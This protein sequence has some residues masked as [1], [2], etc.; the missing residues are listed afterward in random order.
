M[1]R[2][3]AVLLLAGCCPALLCAACTI[4]RSVGAGVDAGDPLAG[5]FEVRLDGPACL[6]Q[7]VRSPTDSGCRVEDVVPNGDGVTFTVRPVPAC[8]TTA[9]PCWRLEARTACPEQQGLRLGLTLD[10]GGTTPPAGS[11]ARARCPIPAT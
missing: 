10:R 4:D 9:P 2:P 8:A 11:F 7:P 5:W 1:I 6:P 3:A